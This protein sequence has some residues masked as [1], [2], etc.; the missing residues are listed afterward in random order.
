MVNHHAENYNQHREIQRL[1]EEMIRK[2]T[3][4]GYVDP[5]P[6]KFHYVRIPGWIS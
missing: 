6:S 4:L 3:T 2:F 5:L 1:K